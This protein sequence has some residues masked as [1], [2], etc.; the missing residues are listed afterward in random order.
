MSTTTPSQT[1]TREKML[2]QPKPEAAPS[3]L[4][5]LTFAHVCLATYLCCLFLYVDHRP[6]W[7]TDIWGHLKYGQWIVAEQQLPK[8]DPFLPETE[9]KLPLVH[10]SWLAQVS[11]YQVFHL[12]EILA[13]SGE[14]EAGG[15]EAL[16]TL[17]ALLTVVTLLCLYGA[18]FR[19]SQSSWVALAGLL[20][21]G[22]FSFPNLALLRPQVWAE[23]FFALLLLAL[24]RPQLRNS[25]LVALP[26]LLAIWANFHGSFMIGLLVM[27]GANGGQ[28]LQ[29][30]REAGGVKLR[31]VMRYEPFRRLFLCI[32]L[33]LLSIGL[34]NPAGFGIYAAALNFQQHP[35]V[36]MMDE[37]RPVAWDTPWGVVF[38][39][40]LL[41]VAVTIFAG[42][43]LLP[44]N[45]SKR[46]LLGGIPLGQILLLLFFS[47]RTYGCQ[48]F[49]LWWVFLAVWVSMSVWGRLWLRLQE[50]L[51][52]RRFS[53]RPRPSFLL[54]LLVGIIVP[55]WLFS[56]AGLW[57]LEGH[58]RP[59]A[60]AVHP[61]TPWPLAQQVRE[62]KGKAFPPLKAWLAS[63][64]KER[65]A[66]RI[67]TS[68]TQGEY[69]LWALPPEAAPLLFC[70]AHLFPPDHWFACQK[71]LNGDK[72][73]QTLLDRLEAQMIVVE[74]ELHP[75]L[76][77]QLLSAAG[78]Q[79][80]LILLDETGDE[81]KSDL[82]SRWLIAVRRSKQLNQ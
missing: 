37:W 80:W 63:Q 69:L 29:A 79:H 9:K 28:F 49:L 3:R 58:P 10:F 56:G 54:L 14:G 17:H 38:F 19:V 27:A 82:R 12:G 5:G 47:W 72:D 25:A 45:T 70:H 31:A 24:S 36:A 18:F 40:S 53:W 55:A 44:K 48:R 8:V 39:A 43:L 4:A 60:R 62:P 15:V 26:L 68:E 61:A 1:S 21:I 42:I 2:P 67:F 52:E 41:F 65:Y 20:A 23:V 35:A 50:R 7:H 57:L 66:G 13:A 76:R 6:L 77:R 75:E 71:I 46:W 74:A 64:G 59:V 11:F 34:F 81:R 78:H 73:W 51:S 32:L 30:C 16:R 22:V 33:S